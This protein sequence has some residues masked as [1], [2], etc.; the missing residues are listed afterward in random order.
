MTNEFKHGEIVRLRPDVIPDQ[1]WGMYEQ[2]YR[3][4]RSWDVIYSLGTRQVDSYNNDIGVDITDTKPEPWHS[5]VHRIWVVPIE[6]L[7]PNYSN[8]E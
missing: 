8:D 3:D 1:T 2:D 5:S 6:H 4:I 7:I